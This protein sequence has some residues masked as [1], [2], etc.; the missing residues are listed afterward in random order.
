[1]AGGR[2]REFDEK[3][4]L[5][6]AMK[7]FWAKGFTGASLTDLTKSMGI[8]KPSMYAAFGNKEQMFILA[9]NNYVD[10]YLSHHLPYLQQSGKNTQQQLIDY[11]TAI[12]DM[13]TSKETPK[14]CFLSLCIA[15]SVSEDWPQQAQA[16][17]DELKNMAEKLL[18]EFF[19]RQKSQG[20]FDQD[21]QQMAQ[22]MVAV[23]HGLAALSRAGKNKKAL[24]QVID[25]TLSVF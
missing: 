17:V 22:F 11:L 7:V 4:A 2:Q 1:M 12:V 18:I 14:G 5:D 13:L 24:M 15:E 25:V 9:L 21:P 16:A 6:N 3:N 23:I 20:D 10:H 19:I 8:N